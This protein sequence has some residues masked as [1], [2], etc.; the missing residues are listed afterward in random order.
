MPR[1]VSIDRRKA[2]KQAQNLFWERGYSAT[3]MS[4]LLDATGM[5]AGSFYAAFNNKASL[6][7]LAIAD[8]AAFFD[9][10]MDEYRTR[11]R[12]LDVVRAFLEQTLVC[13]SDRGRRKGCLLVNSAIELDGVEPELHELV[14]S[15][16]REF[17]RGIRACVEQAHQDGHL[18]GHMTVD[19]ATAM[20]VTHIQGLRVESRLGLSRESASQRLDSL[21]TALTRR[22]QEPL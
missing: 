7:E 20:L 21:F 10:Q 12:G 2:L 22:E 3:P 1:P 5:G 13:T 16:L 11:L 18:T 4:A 14:V 9:K 8:Y 15:Y 17:H 6:F 19:D